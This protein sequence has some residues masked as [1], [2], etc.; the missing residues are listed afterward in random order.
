MHQTKPI[1]LNT[2]TLLFAITLFLISSATSAA[3]DNSNLTVYEALQEYNF[4]IGLLPKG[5]NS[6]ELDSSTGKFSINLNETC[7][8]K[9]D[10]YDLKYATKINGVIEKN[11]LSGLSG[12]QVKVLFVWLNI[13]EVSRVGDEVHF[14]VGIASADFSIGNFVECPACGCGFNCRDLNSREIEIDRLISSS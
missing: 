7:S 5:V 9:I 11:K 8:F 1:S 2:M 10:T 4:P 3:A 13:V 6:Y 14:S 12:I